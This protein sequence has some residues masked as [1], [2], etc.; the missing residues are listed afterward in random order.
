M[1]HPAGPQPGVD[2]V[3]PGL[4][5]LA[6]LAGLDPRTHRLHVGV[7]P[8]AMGHHQRR[9]AGR[10]R[11]DHR[12]ALGDRGRHRLLHQDMR[13]AREQRDRLRRMQRVGR[14]HHRRVDV[15]IARQRLPV[16]R[17][18]G[19]AVAL[20]ERGRRLQP[21]VGDRDDLVATREHRSSVEVLDPSAAEQRHPHQRTHLSRSRPGTGAQS[22]S[23]CARRCRSDGDAR[24]YSFEPVSVTP[25]TK[26]RWARKNKTITGI[27]NMTD[28]AMMRLYSTWCC[29]RKASKPIASV[30]K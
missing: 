5:D 13:A 26:T 15:G 17:D 22:L 28:A 30:N 9:R 18:T 29:P 3:P 7:E 8:P 20:G 25:S 4:H 19:D 12:V 24:G 10:G 14:G 27:M 11:L 1:N 21:V 16:G 23:R 6:Q 2:S